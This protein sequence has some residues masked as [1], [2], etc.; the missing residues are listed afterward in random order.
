MASLRKSQA[1]LPPPPT[2]PLPYVKEVLKECRVIGHKL[3][4]MAGE[5]T[6]C[7]VHYR[8]DPN[9]KRS[10]QDL[11][12]EQYLSDAKMVSVNVTATADE[13]DVVR[14]VEIEYIVFPKRSHA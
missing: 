10:A 14:D 1:L 8:H 4:L 3:S 5:L 7:R 9:G 6:R 12:W 11:H 2:D 13:I